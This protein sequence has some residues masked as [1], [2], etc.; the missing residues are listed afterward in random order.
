MAVPAHDQ[1]DYEFAQQLGLPIRPVV[2]PPEG[3]AEGEAFEAEGVLVNSGPFT[4][5]PS[6]EAKAAITA[7]LEEQGIGKGEIQF[8]MRDWLISRQRY[9]GTPFPVVHCERD[10]IVPL[11]D[12]DLPLLLPED[13]D[14]RPTGEP[15]SPLANATEWVNTTCPT[16]GG[17]AR[18]ETDTMDGFMDSSWYFLRFTDPHNDT[19]I[20]DPKVS[21]AWMPVDQY[22]G[23]MEHAVMHLI[24]ARFITKFLYDIGE[25]SVTEPFRRLMTHGMITLT[26]REMSK[27]T[28]H[29]VEPREV[30][31]RYGVDAL[32]IFI[33]FIGPPT[34]AYD[35]PATGPDAVIPGYR[36]AERVW[37]FVTDNA[38]VL[39]GAGAPQGASELRRAVHRSLSAITE[40]YERFAFNTAIAEL[41]TLHKTLTAA[42]DASPADLREGVD[43]LLRTLAPIAPYLTEELWERI[44][45]EGSVHDQPWP[46][47]DASLATVETVTM[48]IQVDSKVRD[49]VDVAADVSEEDA[50][51]AARAS[52]KVVSALDGRE[53]ARVIARP[54]K[55]VNFVT[56]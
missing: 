23:G 10:G 24:Y 22:T 30:L 14:F 43:V 47:A 55:L 49:K 21:G 26:G 28:G 32:R 50:V 19:Q 1:R 31:D 29:S 8:R 44:G 20:A 40:R 7:H 4:G 3:A 13:V 54:P 9:W 37:R 53:P 15:V 5:R 38:D 27:S 17:P 18:R 52:D 42:K 12:D 46:E 11:S 33:L 56:R 41:M 36:F 6:A 16:C 39:R 2:E 51:A 48:V 45:G 35:W 34:D 25:V